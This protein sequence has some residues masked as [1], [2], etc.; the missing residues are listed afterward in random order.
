MR[1]TIA[2]IG[3]LSAAIL[4]PWI[5]LLCMVLLAARWRAWEVVALG[6]L[7]DILWLSSSAMWGIPFATLFSIVVV[8]ALEPLR[9]ELLVDQ[10][11]L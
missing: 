8:W 6:M 3:V 7:V 1:I 4:S 2:L 5:T 9:N 10:P 11:A